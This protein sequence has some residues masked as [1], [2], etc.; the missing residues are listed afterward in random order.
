M[1]TPVWGECINCATDQSTTVKP[2]SFDS[3]SIFYP[4]WTA[5]LV[6]LTARLPVWG[7]TVTGDAS[8]LEQATKDCF[9]NDETRGA[10]DFANYA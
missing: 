10:S 3:K 6:E 5:V 4:T 8:E 1:M 9:F 2:E 7:G